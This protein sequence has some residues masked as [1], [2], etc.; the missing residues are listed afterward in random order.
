MPK[1]SS[2]K[3]DKNPLGFLRGDFHIYKDRLVHVVDLFVMTVAVFLQTRACRNQLTDQNV[4][5]QTGQRIDLT[6][7]CSI[8]Q[9][10]RG[11]LEGCSGQERLGSQ[12]SLCDTHEYRRSGCKGQSGFACVHALLYLLVCIFQLENGQHC[13]RQQIG[14]ACVLN[15]DLAHHLTNNNFNMLVVQIYTLLTVYLLNF[16]Q[17]VILNGTRIQDTQNVMRIQSAFIEL[18]A[19]R[20]DIAIMY[21]NARGRSQLVAL[22][23]A[24]LLINN[25]Y[26]TNCGT[27]GLFNGNYA[28]DF[29]QSS[30]LLRLSS[31]EQFF[32]SRKTL[33]NI[34]TCDTA[35]MEGTH[36]KLGARL[37]DGLC[38]DNADST[39]H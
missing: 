2:V 31:F 14:V 20:N 26:S 24:S 16:L 22:G 25:V 5:L 35:G 33:R 23:L 37:A 4:L 12:C 11:L 29:S 18:E 1:I 10:T 34:G 17:Q 19:L 28:A 7:D 8:G 32:N 15:L 30:N 9:D 38:C 36:G 13:A 6:L 3:V 27:L 39:L 21:A